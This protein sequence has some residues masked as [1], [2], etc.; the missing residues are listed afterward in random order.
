M[1]CDRCFR[2]LEHGQHGEGLCPYEPRGRAHAVQQDSVEGGFW[3]ENGF[4]QPTYFES[5]QAHRDALAARGMEIRAKWAGPNDKHLSRMD[6][7][8][9]QTLENARI[10]LERG[11]VKKS[12]SQIDPR[13]EF[14]ITVTN[15][16]ETFRYRAES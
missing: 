9:A 6:A 7:P 15:V 3:A 2:S 14:P 8:C 11:K 12:E 10:L 13:E 16:E 5:K 1:T 4:D